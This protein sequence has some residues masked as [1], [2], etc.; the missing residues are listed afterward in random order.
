MLAV[1]I[2]SVGR[3]FPTNHIAVVDT[4]SDENFKG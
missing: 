3:T 1:T 2:F 4:E